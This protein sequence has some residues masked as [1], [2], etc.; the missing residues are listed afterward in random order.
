M[1]CA[2]SGLAFT[3][4]HHSCARVGGGGWLCM[5]EQQQY[6]ICLLLPGHELCYKLISIVEA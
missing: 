3:E 2:G 5:Y 6:H 4:Q 1:V